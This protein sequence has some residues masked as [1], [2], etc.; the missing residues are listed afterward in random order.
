[1]PKYIIVKEYEV[2]ADSVEQAELEI[3]RNKTVP[4]T[5]YQEVYQQHHLTPYIYKVV[6]NNFKCGLFKTIAIDNFIQRVEEQMNRAK[7]GYDKKKDSLID[8]VLDYCKH[9][10]DNMIA[11]VM[12]TDIIIGDAQDYDSYIHGR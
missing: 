5:S 3:D 12:G 6:H 10:P 7:H 9:N 1:M 11:K 8:I 4:K 2:I